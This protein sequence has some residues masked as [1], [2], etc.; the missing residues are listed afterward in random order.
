MTIIENYNDSV[1]GVNSR[2]VKTLLIGEYE[3]SIGFH[4]W[5]QKNESEVVYDNYNSSSYVEAAISSMG[6]TDERVC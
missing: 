1:Y 5:Y 4:V 3:D 6:I 2:F